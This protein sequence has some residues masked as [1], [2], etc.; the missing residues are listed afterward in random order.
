ME[1]ASVL[2]ARIRDAGPATLKLYETFSKTCGDQPAFS[3]IRFV[4]LPVLWIQTRIQGSKI[5]WLPNLPMGSEMPILRMR[6]GA[7]IQKPRRCGIEVEH[8]S[9]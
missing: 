2:T 6:D 5:H 9:A 8:A 4:R 1:G 7:L 3:C